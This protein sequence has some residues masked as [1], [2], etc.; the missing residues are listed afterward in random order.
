MIDNNMS[1]RLLGL[2]IFCLPLFFVVPLALIAAPGTEVFDQYIDVGGYKLHVGCAGAGHPAVILDAG[3]GGTSADWA[4]VQR[5]VSEFTQVCTYDRAGLGLSDQVPKPRHALNMVDDLHTLLINAGIEGP[6]VLVSHSMA[7]FI[8]RLFTSR[9]PAEVAGMVL[10]DASQPD[11]M[12]R[13][14]RLLPPETSGEP[15]TLTAFRNENLEFLS[16][17]LNNPEG[18]DWEVSAEQVR[19]AGPFGTLPVVILRHAFPAKPFPALPSEVAER[20]EMDWQAMQEE[21]LALSDNS[22]LIVA[23]TSNHCIHCETPEVV[24][25]AIRGLIETAQNNAETVDQPNNRHIIENCT[26][27]SFPCSRGKCVPRNFN[28]SPQS[29]SKSR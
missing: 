22:M 8:A 12:T 19:S 16:D 6:Y 20:L 2:L 13:T 15:E 9:Y 3:L 7:G 25:D 11:E 26:F 1:P 10:V 5:Q 21:Q 24:T 23:P 28:I 27:L 14:L 29:Q 17:P 18:V 4:E